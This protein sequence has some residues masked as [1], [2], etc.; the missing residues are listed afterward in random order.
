MPVEV[1]NL[2]S[3]I[4]RKLADP[5]EISKESPELIVRCVFAFH[6]YFGLWGGIGRFGNWTN[7][8]K[9]NTQPPGGHLPKVNPSLEGVE[10][11]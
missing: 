2:F 1:Y 4:V 8:P 3:S 10:G 9:A 6:G 5:T 11:C 7:Y